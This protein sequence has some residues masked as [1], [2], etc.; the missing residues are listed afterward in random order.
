MTNVT[1]PDYADSR[2]YLNRSPEAQSSGVSWGAVLGGAFV[3][4]SSSLILLALGTGFGLADFMT[5]LPN[6]FTQTNATPDDLRTWIMSFYAQ[7]TYKLS[8]KITINLGVRWEPTFADPDKY[9]RGSSFSLAGFNA[10]QVS[11]RG[12][13]SLQSGHGCGW[14]NSAIGRF[15]TN[16]P[17]F[18]HSYS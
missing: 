17:Q 6:D 5:G 1:S 13:A 16:G 8:N 14:S 7:D 9:K 4:A 2:G 15:S 18:S 12:A 3:A 11:S 10:G